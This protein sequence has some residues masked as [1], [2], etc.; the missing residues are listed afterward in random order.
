MG[1]GAT[2]QLQNE[3]TSRL[4]VVRVAVWKDLE[5]LFLFYFCCLGSSLSLFLSL[6]LSLISTMFSRQFLRLTS[7]SLP[8]TKRAFSLS[9]SSSLSSSSRSGGNFMKFLAL[10]GTVSL[11]A[12]S[13]SEAQGVDI[14]A[15]K[16]DI[17]TAIEAE[18]NKRGDGQ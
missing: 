2:L 16:K 18:A 13:I 7:R 15:V 3:Q 1:R 4:M 9:L 6:S 10:S 17:A 5:G 12:M 11:I 14:E 8:F